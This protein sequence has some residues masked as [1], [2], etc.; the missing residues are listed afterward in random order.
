VGLLGKADGRFIGRGGLTRY[1]IDGDSEVGLASA[2][3]SREWG[4]GDATE[5]VEASLGVG[6]ARLRLPE[7]ATWTLPT[8][9]SSQRVME[10]LGFRYERDIVFA[11]L[12]HRYYRIIA[13]E[14]GGHRGRQPEG[15]LR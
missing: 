8:N 2:V 14:W 3:L 10:K 9:R 6:C 11:G 4:R 12:P 15:L 13:A 1:T 7:V 5:M